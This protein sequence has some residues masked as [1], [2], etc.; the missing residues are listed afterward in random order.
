MSACCRRESGDR[1]HDLE[2]WIDSMG[3]V[4]VMIEMYQ[5]D[6]F[7]FQERTVIQTVLSRHMEPCVKISTIE[8]DGT[9]FEVVGRSKH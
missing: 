6:Y 3:G 8:G 1:G 7:I 4:D 2:L 9:T 5:G